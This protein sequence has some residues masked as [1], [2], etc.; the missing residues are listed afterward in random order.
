MIEASS[1]M[2]LLKTLWDSR[3]L[4]NLFISAAHY[5]EMKLKSLH[6]KTPVKFHFEHF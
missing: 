6:H 4:M 5:Q 2:F 1:P 3:G